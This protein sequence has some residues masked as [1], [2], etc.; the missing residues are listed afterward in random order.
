MCSY[1]ELCFTPKRREKKE[2]HSEYIGG[3]KGA[4][5][6]ILKANTITDSD[7]KNNKYYS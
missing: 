4:L 5:I 7:H 1:F 6:R 2:F 3:F